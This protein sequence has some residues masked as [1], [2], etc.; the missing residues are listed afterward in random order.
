MWCSVDSPQNHAK[1][2]MLKTLKN[3]SHIS[4][5]MGKGVGIVR[6]RLTFVS[7]HFYILYIY[8]VLMSVL[9]IMLYSSYCICM[10]EPIQLKNVRGRP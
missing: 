6:H 10:Y 1:V 3:L 5:V 2:T 9:H 8:I 4:N 7:V